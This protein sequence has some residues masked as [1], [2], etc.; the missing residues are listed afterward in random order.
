MIPWLTAELV[1]PPLESALTERDG[2]NGLLAAGGDLSS[3]RLLAAYRRG[4]FPWYSEGDPLL[5]W[6]PNP[7][8][9]LVPGQLK[10]SRSL[11]RVLRHADYEIRLDTAFA[12]VI[13]ACACAP[14]IGQ[15]GTWIS[16]EM[17]DAY[18]ELH[19]LGYAHSVETWRDGNLIGG[20]A[21][22]WNAATD[23]GSH[24]WETLWNQRFPPFG[25]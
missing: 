20:C 4:I 24:R 19:R 14:R 7:R 1:F 12:K 10:I 22:E 16:P 11:T 23:D 9:V 21:A 8:M 5:W 15:D 18:I 17:Q 2:A 6:S 3:Q 13:R 25:S